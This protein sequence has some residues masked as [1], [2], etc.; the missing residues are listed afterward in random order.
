MP[1]TGQAV[2]AC[3]GDPRLQPRVHRRLGRQPRPAGDPVGLLDHV[4]RLAYVWTF[5][6][7]VVICGMIAVGSGLIDWRFLHRA[8][9]EAG[10]VMGHAV[11]WT[12]WAWGKRIRDWNQPT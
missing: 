3:R 12:D 4:Q 11:C 8:T 9:P 1:A 10:W 6:W 7:L 5:R 2:G